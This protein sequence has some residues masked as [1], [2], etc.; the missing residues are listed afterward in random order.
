M[1]RIFKEVSLLALV[2]AVVFCG[3]SNAAAQEE[4]V[5]DVPYE[6]ADNGDVSIISELES[7]TGDSQSAKPAESAKV[8]P[9]L[10]FVSLKS[11]LKIGEDRLP[12]DGE[13]EQVISGRPIGGVPPESAKSQ[14]T[15]G[16]LGTDV[17]NFTSAAN[18]NAVSYKS[19]LGYFGLDMNSLSLGVSK[20]FSN[21]ITSLYYN[22]N[23]IDDLFAYIANNENAGNVSIV[24]QNGGSDFDTLGDWL[25]GR[26]EM[27]SRTNI[28]VLFGFGKFGINVGYS[29]RLTGFIRDSELDIKKIENSFDGEINAGTNAA[30]VNSIAPSVEFGFQFGD[31]EKL[32]TRLTLAGTYNI[33]AHREFKDGKLITLEDYYK[34]PIGTTYSVANAIT[35]KTIADYKEPALLIRAEFEFPSDENSRLAIGIELGWKTKLYSNIDD[36]GDIV[37]G[38]YYSKKINDGRGRFDWY[39]KDITDMTFA[40]SPSIRYIT[41]M[42]KK[43]TLGL[44]GN[45]GLEYRVYKSVKNEYFATNFATFNSGSGIVPWRSTSE[46]TPIDFLVCPQLGIGVSY[47]I[48]PDTFSL[49]A[50]VGAKQDLYSFRIGTKTVKEPGKDN[51]ET[52]IADEAWGKPAAQL[53]LGATFMFNKGSAL[54]VQ[55]SANGIELKNANFVIQ[56]SASF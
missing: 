44:S 38:I 31:I 13:L 42:S 8:N 2:L 26:K 19:G 28:N 50:G 34:D 48:V 56:F 5:T 17:D 52:P 4:T 54:D 47:D 9:K 43:L 16:V 18:F 35:Q 23:I 25:N 39:T 53:A 15:L 30:V 11:A 36:K 20:R 6:A 29:Q 45:M 41:A 32:I 37:E 14:I 22:G 27:D 1:N 51:V 24:S 33:H 40:G 46:V 3:L 12:L 55:F 21:A 49:N 7:N 10:Q